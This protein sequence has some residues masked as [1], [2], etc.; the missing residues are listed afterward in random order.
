M[1]D[2]PKG[3]PY[4]TPGADNNVPAHLF[5]LAQWNDDNPGIAAFTTVARDLLIGDEL[6]DGRVIRNTTA[7]RLQ[8]YDLGTDT[9]A[10][11]FEQTDLEA[12]V[13]AQTADTVRLLAHAELD[14]ATTVTDITTTSTTPVDIDAA[15]AV[16]VDVPASGI[17]TIELEAMAYNPATGLYA[18]CLREGSTLV[19]GSPTRVT[20]FASGGGTADSQRVRMS[21]RL[22]G[23]TPGSHTYKWAHMCSA[24]A[25]GIRYG[26]PDDN[27]RVGKAVM[28]GV[29]Q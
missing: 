22:T 12:E 23:Q 7:D 11:L 17:V 5:A 15:L 6:W 26:G 20:T 2:T 14:N 28:R 16:T 13:A 8:V 25:F 19:A 9:W 24:S 3:V 29:T 1:A 27:T 18:W 21:I 4:P 10:T